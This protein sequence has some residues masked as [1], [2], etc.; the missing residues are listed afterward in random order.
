MA[1][2]SF[3]GFMFDRLGLRLY[4][5]IGRGEGLFRFV[6]NFHSPYLFSNNDLIHSDLKSYSPFLFKLR[7]SQC[8][9]SLRHFLVLVHKRKIKSGDLGGCL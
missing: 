6:L 4:L 7:T 1:A 2:S 5:Q 8:S 9:R 3:Y